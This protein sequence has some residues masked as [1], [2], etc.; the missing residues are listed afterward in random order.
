M[1]QTNDLK[2]KI[3]QCLKAM[4]MYSTDAV[5]L[6]MGTAAQESHFKY[7]LQIGGGPALGYFQMEPKTFVDIC[8]NYLLFQPTELTATIMEVAN[9][10]RFDPADLA[11]NVELMVC[12][13][14][15]HYY[16]VAD[17]LPDNY[18]GFARY[19]KKHY[20]TYQG[21]GTVSE[22]ENNYKLLVL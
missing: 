17:P 19:W 8:N 20:N 3:I 18:H 14:R 12:F 9:V 5:M 16:R 6:L 11:H 15:L 22:F 2:R 7:T 10:D 1:I 21:K 4:D 13:A